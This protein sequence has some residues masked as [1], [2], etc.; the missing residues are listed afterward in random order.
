MS[1]PWPIVFMG[2]PQIAAITLE[3]LIQ[4]PDPVAGVVT[5][6]DRPAGRGQRTYSIAGA[7]SCRKSRHSCCR[8]GKD[9]R[10]R[11]SENFDG[12]EARD[13]CGCSLRT[14]PAQND[15]RFSA[16]RMPQRTLFAIAKVPRGCTG[17][18][19]DHQWRVDS[20]G[21]NDETRRE[22]GCWTDLPAG[23]H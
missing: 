10:S 22:N 23:S 17:C 15:S 11:I 13:H 7:K 8:S 20:R 2:T 18:L 14:H 5:Q 16:I 6:P 4:G 3:Q 9:P 12:M 1:T 19:D 21:H